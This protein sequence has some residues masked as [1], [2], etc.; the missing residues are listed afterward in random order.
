MLKNHPFL[1]PKNTFIWLANQKNCMTR[2]WKE[3]LSLFCFLSKWKEIERELVW[4]VEG[5]MQLSDLL[6]KYEE[7]M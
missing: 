5:I 4:H 3:L 6:N 1:N 7:V 2:K